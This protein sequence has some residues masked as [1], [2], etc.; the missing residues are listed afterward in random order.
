MRRAMIIGATL[1][2]VLLAG[3][4]GLSFQNLPVGRAPTGESYPMTAVF[5]DASGLPTGGLIRLGQSAVGRVESVEAKDFT[6]I[7][8]MNIASSVRI[9]AGTTARLQLPSPLGEEFLVLRPPAGPQGDAL[10]P[11]AT[12]PLNLTS[13]GPD[14]ENLFAALGMLLGGSG[15]Q[16]VSTIVAESNKALDGREGE[17]RDLL[18]RLHSVLGTFES[19][20]EQ[21]ATTLDSVDRLASYTR[22]NQATIDAALDR[23]TP[24]IEALLAQK[25]SFNEL[26]AKIRPLADSVNG[27]VG[28]TSDQFTALAKN[29]RPP[30]DGLAAMN[31]RIGAVLAD[32]GRL[33]PNVKAGIPGDYITVS[34]RLDVPEVV[35]SLLGQLVTGGSTKL[36]GPGG[37]GQL[38]KGVLR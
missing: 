7:V 11:G 30:L 37:P 27:V 20:R 15:L 25:D 19:H 36:L 12:I 17:V 5:D 8:H 38:L 1:V 4:C 6:A 32:V 14:I 31:D 35:T 10:A 26:V 28:S 24:G 33:G 34:G 3:G 16:Q 9:P 22:E 2:A 23:I 13:R 21:I 18:D 29:I